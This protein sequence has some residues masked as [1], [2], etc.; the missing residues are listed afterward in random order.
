MEPKKIFEEL[1]F[2][3]KESGFLSALLGLKRSTVSALGKKTLMPRTTLY[4]IIEKL[5]KRG[6]IHKVGVGNHSEWE[7]LAP[8]ALYR[9]VKSSLNGFKENLPELEKMYG[10]DT[11]VKIPAVVT[12]Y[13][14]HDG[15]KKAYESILRLSKGER[16]YSIEGVRSV[17]AKLKH[18]KKD[19][20][21]E[22]QETFKKKGVII[23]GLTGEGTLSVLKKMDAEHLHA[24]F[25]KTVIAG[26][27]PDEYLDFET[28]MFCFHN[29]VVIVIPARDRVVIIQSPEIA[30]MIQNLFRLAQHFSRKI[31]LNAFVSGLIAE[32]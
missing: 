6:L 28:D 9:K 24:Q 21:V 23:E 12:S 7:V 3:A 16:V 30:R 4:T 27:L 19:Y 11:A 18:F 15:M 17:E 32:K 2:S 5:E 20:V 26:L 25:G 29:T 22:W 13:E 14:T 1:G 8:D 10:A 31:D